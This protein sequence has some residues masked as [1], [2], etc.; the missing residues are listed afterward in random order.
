MVSFYSFCDFAGANGVV[1]AGGFGFWEL[2]FLVVG[3]NSWRRLRKLTEQ[4]WRAATRF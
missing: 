1:G 3:L 2:G 4:L